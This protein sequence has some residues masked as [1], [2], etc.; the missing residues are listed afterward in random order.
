MGA[1]STRSWA[2]LRGIFG[3]ILVP[4]WH[5]GI[6]LLRLLNY[7]RN[8]PGSQGAGK[9]DGERKTGGGSVSSTIGVSWPNFG[10][11]VIAL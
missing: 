7:S 6:G 4:S 1:W 11:I 5:H 8:C 9:G 3:I 10:K 2:D